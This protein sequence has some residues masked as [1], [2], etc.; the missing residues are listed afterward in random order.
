MAN[1]IYTAITSLDGYVADREGNFD[2][3]APDGEV[4]A[5]VHEVSRP[6]GTLLFGRRMYD[7]LVAWDTLDV[8]DEPD[9]IKDFKQIWDAADKIVYSRTLDEPRS[10]RTRID[11]GFDPAVI[12]GLKRSSERDLAIGGPELAA[13]ALRAGLVDELHQFVNPVVVGGGTPWLPDDVRIDLELVGERSF[14]GGVVQL[15][16]RTA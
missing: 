15:H 3:S 7:V 4:H 6:V 13:Q 2:W 10:S 5:V 16:Y 12:R 14:S 9:E 8:A 11:R 1:L